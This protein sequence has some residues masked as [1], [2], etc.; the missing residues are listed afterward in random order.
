MKTEPLTVGAEAT[1][2]STVCLVSGPDICK[3]NPD[4][5]RCICFSLE[6]LGLYA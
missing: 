6:N 1:V 4:I 2:Y 3:Q 5:F